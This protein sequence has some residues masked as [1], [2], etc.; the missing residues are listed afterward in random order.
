MGSVKE[1]GKIIGKVKDENAE[2]IKW[3]LVERMKNEVRRA[4]VVKISEKLKEMKLRCYGQ[5]V[6]RERELGEHGGSLLWDNN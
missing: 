6:R 1:R 4:G 2:M 3:K 5:L